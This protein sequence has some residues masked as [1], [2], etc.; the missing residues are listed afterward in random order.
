MTR[1]LSRNGLIYL[2]CVSNK[3]PELKK[4]NCFVNDLYLVNDKDLW[5]VV[6][7]V[8]DDEFSEEKLKKSLADFE[9]VKRKASL[10]EKIIEGVMEGTCVIPFKF[11]TLFASEDNL[12]G[13]LREQA[14]IL[15]ENLKALEGKE[16]WGVKI[17]C[18]RK[19]LKESL[20]EE[21]EMI[22]EI[23]QEISSSSPGRAFLLKKKKEEL[24]NTEMNI[25]INEYGR[26]SFYSLR[27][28]SLQSSFN[29]LLPKEVTE[30][31]EDMIL[32]ST[33][34]LDKKRASDFVHAVENLRER[35]GHKGFLFDCT[36]P[37]PPYNF[38]QPSPQTRRFLKKKKS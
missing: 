5:A 2:Y 35:Y 18:D 14:K 26:E 3:K 1:K 8:S 10:H 28:Q 12:K 23:N 21:N 24:L 30:R 34:L 33:F 4:I 25:K 20:L 31:E 9:W 19:K 16:E 22:L 36:G 11:A 15:K 38:C 37:W 27:E 7:K 32:N 6:S 13:M 29:K 17:Y